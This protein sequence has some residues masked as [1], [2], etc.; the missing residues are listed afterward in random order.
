M[1]LSADG[2]HLLIVIF[3]W[4]GGRTDLEWWD[5]LTGKRR[6]TVRVR[7]DLLHGVRLVGP[8]GPSLE[9]ISDEHGDRWIRCRS[10]ADGAVT[11]ERMTGGSFMGALCLDP[12]RGRVA[13]GGSD[14]V[15]TL[16]DLPDL[17]PSGRIL[18]PQCPTMA[19]AFSPDGSRLA[20][21]SALDGLVVVVPVPTP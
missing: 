12:E 7:C 6:W 16:F 18:L 14:G 20:A 19:M 17:T 8:E 15:V 13:S 21:G 4:E 3:P 10:A 5:V 2:A 11:L 1:A 9:S